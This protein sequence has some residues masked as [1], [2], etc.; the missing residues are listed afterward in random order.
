MMQLILDFLLLRDPNLRWVVFAILLISGS[1]AVVGSFAFLRKRALIGDAISHAVLP[2]ICGA[3]LLTQSKNTFP[4]LIGATISGLLALWCFQYITKYSKIKADAA[5][6][7]IL[8]VFY[9]LG[10]LMLGYIQNQATGK[11]AG[12][13]KF[14]FG[15][16]ATMTFDDVLL[17]GAFS[18]IVL[19]IVLV[20]FKV[21][22]MISFD[23]D[24][25]RVRGIPVDLIE[26]LLSVLT[27]VAIALGIQAVGVILMSALLITPAAIA[28]YWT[29]HLITM[30]FIAVLVS[31]FAAFSG[32]FISY[33][34][35][36]SPTG[37]WVVMSL[38]VMV[39]FS[40]L[41]GTKKGLLANY[42]QQK[43]NKQKIIAENILKTIYLL[44]EKNNF[45]STTNLIA[46]IL[47]YRHFPTKELKR[48]LQRL[49]YK[50][51]IKRQFQSVSLTPKGK[52]E[53]ARL[54]RIHRLWEVYLTRYLNLPPDHIHEDAEA[55]E[56]LITP[57]IE[58][59]LM[60]Y[61]ERPD[62]DPHNSPI[63]Y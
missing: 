40:I 2:G 49:S 18:S 57:T 25:A 19:F 54:V 58:A 56:H 33:I 5:L 44:Q 47:S 43:A 60:Q 53:G 20:F 45:T 46:E 61:L 17:F 9:G 42:L 16:A 8:S 21:F 38:T 41:L 23:I 52:I 24:Y 62:R 31:S 10:A 1:A 48:G 39:L 6:A 27:V 14:L 4:L 28:R 12:L 51:L 50:E 13:D 59:D 35:P 63:P 34:F 15:K 29:H 55:M 32:T 30:L 22:K 26:L 7:I 36:K 11:Q 37:P 3:F